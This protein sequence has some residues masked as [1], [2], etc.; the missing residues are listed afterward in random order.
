MILVPNRRLFRVGTAAQYLGKS[1]GTIRKLAELNLIQARA[2]LDTTGR[3][4]LHW[5]TLTPTLILWRR[6]TIRTTAKN[7]DPER[8]RCMGIHKVK[9]RRER[10][11]YVFS[12]YW[13][14]GPSRLRMYAPHFR[15]A[16]ALQTLELRLET[17]PWSPRLRPRTSNTVEWNPV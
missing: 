2:E 10:R 11:R 15:P 7:L 12:K 13:P 4:P 8:R 6:G 17:R 1:I 14:N 5:R 9:D 16:Q 3:P